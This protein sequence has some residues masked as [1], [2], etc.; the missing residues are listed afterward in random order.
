MFC[1]SEVRA[2]LS[3]TLLYP[4]LLAGCEGS[5]AETQRTRRK[6]KEIILSAF[7]GALCV[8]ALKLI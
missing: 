6:E 5:N 1:N 3:V 2:R 4:D 7:L 8:S